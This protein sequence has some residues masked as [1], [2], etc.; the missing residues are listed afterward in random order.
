MSDKITLRKTL[1]LFNQESNTL[2]RSSWDDLP[3]PF[4]RFLERIESQPVI[5]AYLDECVSSHTPDGFDATS[6]VDA[7][8]NDYGA[9]F[10]PFSTDP[11]EESAQV[12]LI[13]KELIAQDIRGDSVV[14]YGYASKKFADMYKAFLDRVAR[15]LI[16]NIECHL[17]MI[18][19]EMGLDSG[20]GI[21]NNF[22][23]P[24]QTAQL[25][26]PTEGSTVNATQTIGLNTS[27]LNTLLDAILEAANAEIEDEDTISDIRDNVEIVRVQMESGEPKRG[28]IKGAFS[29]LKGVNGGVQFAA[30][31]AQIAEFMTNNGIQLPFPS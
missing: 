2:L 5:K 28:I 10:G 18:G 7:V 16:T 19:I 27:E 13:L 21:T 22:N 6:E 9:I 23:G 3:T 26:Q 4:R 20:D 8:A 12:Y 14:F 29:F 1:Y 24:V 17:N 25:N 15:R 31:I 11:E 30:A